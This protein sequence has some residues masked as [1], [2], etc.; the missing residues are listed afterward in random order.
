[1]SAS[2]LLTGAT[3]YIGGR[4][5]RCFEEGGH[6]VRCLV[7][8]PARL[9]AIGSATE[10]VQGD[11]LDEASLDRALAG[12]H[13]AYYL[14]HSMGGGSDFADVDR[15]AAGNFGRAAARAGVRR[16]IYLGGLTGD[17]ESL[18]TH[19]RSRAETGDVL[20]ASGVPVIEFR[21]SIVIGAGSLSFE[22]IQALVER[23]PVMICPRWVD[24]L[25]QPIAIEDV[26]AYLAAA[27]DLPK[28]AGSRIFE[29]GGPEIVSYGDMMRDY[30]RLRDLMP[31]PAA[32]AAANAASVRP[33]ARPRDSSAGARRAGAGGRIE[34]FDG[35]PIIGRGRH[36]S[37]P[38]DAAARGAHRRDRRWSRRATEDRYA[39]NR[40]RCAA[41]ASLRANPPHRRRHRLV[42]RYAALERAWPAGPLL[43]RR[44][45]G[46]RAP[47][48]GALRRERRHRRVDCRSVRA[49]SPAAAVS[50]SQ[51]ARS[52]LA[53]VRGHTARRRAAIDDPSNGHI[54]SARGAGPRV[55]VRHS[56]D[57]RSDVPR[58]ARADCS[59]CLSRHAMKRKVAVNDLMQRGYVYHRTEPVGRNFASGF[60][61][62]LTPKQMLRAGVFGGKY[63]TDCRGEFPS[64]WFIGVKLCAH[65]HDARLNFF[66]VNASQ[67]LAVWRRMGWIRPQD[68]RGWFQWYCRYYMG[69]RSADDARQIRRWRAI[70]RH[71]SAI[72]KQLREG[73]PR[74]PP[75]AKAGGVALGLRQSQGLAAVIRIGISSCLL[76]Q[77][78]RFDGG[79]KRDAFLTGTFGRF[80]EWVPVCPCSS[81][82]C[83]DT[84]NGASKSSRQRS[85]AATCSRRI[86]RAAV[87]SGSGST[88]P[89]KFR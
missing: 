88:A 85:C 49:R 60:S 44:R 38:A 12:V 61:P 78:V 57:S 54:R 52:R 68:P 9:V 80:V 65:R 73:R 33:L 8:E 62:E 21:A 3:G 74:V 43:R 86:H 10:T 30:A 22:M 56:S 63:M 41:R 58:H 84:R 83:R 71:V 77:A 29:I 6:A 79:H 64:S 46:P 89:T 47:R 16:V 27:L 82:R 25:T 76:G 67:S 1:M 55:L 75:A 11:C 14:V 13:S 48:P 17:I 81:I 18:S 31:D 70:A 24:T 36:L 15:R 45:H 39:Y 40:S 7:R 26:L 87:S 20:R 37:D 35:R 19:L 72:R 2:I 66:G 59:A 34:K 51:T 23:L 69:R 32:R 5:L 28:G 4:L 50:R 42:F 53:G